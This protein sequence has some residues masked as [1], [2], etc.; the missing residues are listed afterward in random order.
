MPL[1]SLR[2][3][4]RT[5]T[6]V[7][8]RL[9]DRN[10]LSPVDLRR[11][12]YHLRLNRGGAL[13]ARCWVLVEGETEAWLVPEFARLC[14]VEFPGEGIRCVEF[15]QCGVTP[16][17]KL[18]R[19]MR[20]GWLLLADGDAAGRGYVESARSHLRTKADQ[21]RIILLD[22]KDIEHYLFRHG[23][24]R[25]ISDAAGRTPGASGDVTRRHPGSLIRD[26]TKRV[27][28]PG[29]ALA[30]LEAANLRGPE[31]VPPAMRQLAETA[32]AVARR[33]AMPD[34]E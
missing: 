25:V 26:A 33:A 20:I 34:E 13:F 10:V 30:M 1:R 3:L 31:R 8:A 9:V 23:F 19:A 28:K 24:A 16:L 29:L 7:Q 11:V 27:S 18:A 22:E 14:G 21:A 17:I 4:V 6:G 32:R 15:A 12:S 2:R 5:N